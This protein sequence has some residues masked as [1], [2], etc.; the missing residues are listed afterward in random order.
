L[1]FVVSC[2]DFWGLIGDFFWALLGNFGVFGAVVVLFEVR[3]RGE[4]VV[5]AWLGVVFC[6]WGKRRLR[7]LEQVLGLSLVEALS[8][9]F[10]S[11][12]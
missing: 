9:E 5:D 7:D 10:R 11:R 1:V 3:K 2:G 8:E 4:I 12:G 6:W